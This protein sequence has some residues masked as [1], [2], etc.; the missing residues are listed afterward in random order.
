MKRHRQ[1]ISPRALART[2]ETVTGTLDLSDKVRLKEL[3]GEGNS[4]QYTC[5]FVEAGAELVRMEGT[6]QAQLTLKC[7]RCQAPLQYDFSHTF[8]FYIMLSPSAV[9]PDGEEFVEVDE[10]GLLDLHATMEDE[11]SL[12]MPMFVSHADCS[13]EIG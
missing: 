6:L 2:G 4:L 3:S 11:L 1:I 12:A 13:A 9:V 10:R 7:D 5:C 8:A